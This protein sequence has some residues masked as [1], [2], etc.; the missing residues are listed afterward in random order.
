MYKN[1]KGFVYLLFCSTNIV[2]KR[3]CSLIIHKIGDTLVK[4]T[5]MR[6]KTVLK[7]GF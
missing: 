4:T 5:D 7:K 3:K 1:N 2:T 6:L